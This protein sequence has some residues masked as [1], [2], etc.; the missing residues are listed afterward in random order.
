MNRFFLPVLLLL[1]ACTFE[2]S[3]SGTPLEVVVSEYPAEV[4]R[5]G[6]FEVTVDVLRVTEPLEVA[7]TKPEGVEVAETVGPSYAVL[8]VAVGAEVPPTAQTV[9]VELRSGEARAQLALGFTVT[10][11]V[12]ASGVGEPGVRR[13]RV[14]RDGAAP[15]PAG[16]VP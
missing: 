12:G 14:F 7:V 15:R 16:E 5:G 2:L 1:G 4:A 13:P 11:E 9:T 3:G 6:S 10:G 8:T